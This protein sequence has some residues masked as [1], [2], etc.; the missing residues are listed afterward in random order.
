[1]AGAGAGAGPAAGELGLI[2]SLLEALL[3]GRVRQVFLKQ[4]RDAGAADTACYQAVV[5]APAQ[6][7][8]LRWCPSLSEWTITI[9]PLDSHPIANELGVADQTTRL[10]CQLDFDMTVG[11]GTVVSPAPPAS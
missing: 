4:F 1:R 10:T 6:I 8:N 2:A 3:D 9:H 11:A 7:S 5:E